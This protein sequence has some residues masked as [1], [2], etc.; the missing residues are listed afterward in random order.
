VKASTST[1]HFL[2]TNV[3]IRHANRDSG[4][5][6]ND[7]QTILSDAVAK[8]RRL[9]VSSILFAELRQSSFAPNGVFA[10]VNDLA[11]YI[12]SVADVVA[13]DAATGL[14]AARLR[15]VKWLRS[16]N[17]MPNEQPRCMSLGDALHVCCALWVK[18]NLK[19]DDLDFLTFDDGRSQ[20][21]ELDPHTKS[22]SLLRLDEYTYNINSDTDVRAV[23]SLK[24]SR[25]LLRVLTLDF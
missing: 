8:R 18:E 4:N 7:I 16:R 24:R 19:V 6:E 5:C 22:L 1:N 12:H 14:R 23:L 3:L 13:P 20:T 15:D 11:R 25:P 21:S 9:W 10:N 2:D 17:R